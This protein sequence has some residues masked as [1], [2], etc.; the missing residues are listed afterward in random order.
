MVRAPKTILLTTFTTW[1]AHQ[2]S[3]SSDD[4]VAGLW[5][6]DRCP[7]GLHLL[8]QLPVDFQAAPYRVIR[9]IQRLKPDIV[10]CCGMAE[11]RPTL[12]VEANGKGASGV[13]ETSLDLPT[14]IQPLASTQ[15][16]Q[17]A[18][19]FVCNH[20]YY[21]VLHYLQARRLPIQ[22]LFI[23]VPLLHADNWA[24]IAADFQ[25]LLRQL[26]GSSLVNGEAATGG[27]LRSQEQSD[28]DQSAHLD[29][30]PDSS[31]CCPSLRM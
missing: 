17:D 21:A 7:P 5:P 9:A 16:S 13:L 29:P 25:A 3:N 23:H 28:Y 20:L 10:L 27:T 12:T 1:A 30:F 31:A 11:Q 22:S 18:G 4:L 14:L 26:Q 8:R 19:A 6:H 15:I 2:R 24:A